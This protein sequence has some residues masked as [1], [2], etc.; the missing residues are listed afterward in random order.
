VYRCIVADPPWTP[1]MSIINGPSTGI[2]APKGSPQRQYGTLGLDEIKELRIPAAKQSHLYLWVLTQHTNWGHEVAEAWG[3][4]VV[5]MLTWC[6]PG[7][8]VGRFRCNTEHV[9]VC[10]RGNR[11]GNPFGQGGRHAQATDRTWFQWPRGSHSEKPKEFMELVE[12][13]SPEPRLEL[14]ARNTRHGWDSWGN[15]VPV[16]SESLFDE[17]SI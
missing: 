8:G 14:F 3:F 11:I 12:R 10:R 9:L 13:I 5:T 15:Q 4:Y 7:L 17:S 6:K 16:A 1:T 2:G